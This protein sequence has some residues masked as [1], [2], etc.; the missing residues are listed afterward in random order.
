MTSNP[1]TAVRRAAERLLLAYDKL[2]GG[3]QSKKEALALE[4]LTK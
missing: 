4:E 2:Q 3:A 1:L